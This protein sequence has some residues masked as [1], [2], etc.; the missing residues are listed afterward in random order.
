M[1]S[2]DHRRPRTHPRAGFLLCGLRDASACSCCDDVND[3][4]PSEVRALIS[5]EF[6]VV[7]DRTPGALPANIADALLSAATLRNHQ[8]TEAEIVDLMRRGAMRFG[9]YEG[10]TF[11]MTIECGEA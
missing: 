2:T 5:G 11:T 9:Y 8:F 10:S 7:Y 3:P 4:T 6:D 1:V